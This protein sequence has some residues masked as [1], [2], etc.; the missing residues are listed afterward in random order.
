MIHSLIFLMRVHSELL[1]DTHAPQIFDPSFTHIFV[2]G[3]L[4]SVEENNENVKP[5]SAHHTDTCFHSREYC[6]GTGSFEARA[7]ISSW[8]F[9]SHSERLKYVCQLVV[10]SLRGLTSQ[11]CV[12][13]CVFAYFVP[14]LI[15]VNFILS[16]GLLTLNNRRA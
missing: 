16:A 5:R 9:T 6:R 10:W 7:V 1:T 8:L 15:H 11:K 12:C 2:Y 3:L 4:S 13:V 14:I